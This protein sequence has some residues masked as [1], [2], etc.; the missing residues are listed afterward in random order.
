MA[1]LLLAGFWFFNMRG[2]KEEA[3]EQL[4]TRAN[5]EFQGGQVPLALQDFRQ[6]VERNSGTSAGS[7]GLYYL[8]NAYFLVGDYQQAELYFDKFVKASAK[9]PLL[10]A[11]AYAGRALCLEKRGDTKAAAA[12][13]E[14]A[15]KISKDSPQ[16]PDYLVGAIRARSV[17]GDSVQARAQLT[18]LRKDF[19]LFRGHLNE[20]LL[21]MGRHGI[22]EEPD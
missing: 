20:A 3:A 11:S 19:P 22:Y 14:Q 1:V 10:T 21:H 7:E 2:K 5:F 8:A 6:L 12:A 18:R 17:L 15:A 13:F 9:K 16:T 4:L